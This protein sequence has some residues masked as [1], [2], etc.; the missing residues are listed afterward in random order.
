MAIVDLIVGELREPAGTPEVELAATA[1]AAAR[2]EALA[3]AAAVAGVITVRFP[4]FSDGRGFTQAR[5]L[6]IEHA[7]TGEIRA[8]GPLLPDQAL[9]LLRAGFDSVTLGE[10]ANITH[11]QQA[12]ARFRGAYQPAVRNPLELRRDGARG[13]AEEVAA[14]IAAAGSLED[15][16]LEIAAIPGRVAFSSSLGLEDQA[17]THAIAATRADIDVFT[18]D[19]GRHF[20]ETLETLAASEARYG[21]KIRVVCPDRE[22]V[23]DLVAR[24]GV[25]GFRTSIDARKACCEVRKVVPLRRALEGASAWI[26]GLRRDQS[27][28]RAE[29][30]FA[31]WDA[32]LGILKLNPL[33][34]WGLDQ[35]EAYIAGNDVPVSALHAQGYPS[36]GCQPCTRAIRPGEHIRAGRWWWE[37]EDGKECGL[38]NRPRAQG[39]A[40]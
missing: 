5:L 32:G 12:L 2:G 18:L 34:D 7:Y 29:A 3:Q 36:I 38:H 26:T 30:A 23:E 37:N 15:R 20:P 13:L 40:A 8:V 25:F 27:D 14:R 19:T 35:L 28:G 33:A 10:G 22:A 9:H 11:W 17:L 4:K 1:D 39:E 24:D 6:R 21:L 31:E 16:I